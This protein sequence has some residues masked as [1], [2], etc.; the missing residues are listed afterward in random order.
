MAKKN[1]QKRDPSVTVAVITALSAIIVAVVGGIFALLQKQPAASSTPQAT[2]MQIAVAT[3][4]PSVNSNFGYTIRVQTND[5]GMPIANAKVTIE[6]I[7]QA[8]LDE[9]ADSNGVARFLIDSSR[10]G[11][12]ARLIVRATGYKSY[13]Q[14]IDLRQG[15]LPDVIPLDLE[16]TSSLPATAP[17][18]QISQK[19]SIPSFSG[20][21]GDTAGKAKFF[22]FL[23]SNERN[24]VRLDVNLSEDQANTASQNIVGPGIFLVDLT[25]KDAQGFP[26][27][28]QLLIDLSKGSGDFYYDDRL[29]SLRIESN[30]KIVGI[31]GPQM[32]IF[33]VS[34]APVSIE[35]TP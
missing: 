4:S 32:G 29:T 13:S 35:S 21:I 22:D 12:P 7:G 26:T 16:Q 18:S 3:F 9:I 25:D 17:A 6:V 20:Y 30:L 24:V 11:Q 28:A 31:Q 19:P 27:G 23:V 14:N 34:A 2:P 8:P 33:S 10:V 5:A 1:Q 15:T